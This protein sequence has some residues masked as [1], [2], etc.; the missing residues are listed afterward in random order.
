MPFFNNHKKSNTATFF[1][2]TPAVSLA[3]FVIEFVLAFY[4]L[5]KYRATTFSKLCVI[6]LFCLGLFQLSEFLICKTP[7][8]NLAIKIG[9]VSITLLPALGMNV[10]SVVTKQGKYIT[11]LAYIFAAIL[12]AAVAPRPWL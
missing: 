3:T 6:T 11:Y 8:I 2:F 12:V 5:F 7:H 1:C 4:V 9:Y 10:I